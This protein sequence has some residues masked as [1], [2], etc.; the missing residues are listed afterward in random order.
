MSK[1]IEVRLSVRFR[2]VI[3]KPDGWREGPSVA[4]QV[5]DDVTVGLYAPALGVQLRGRV[6]GINSK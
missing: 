3:G 4:E 5:E 2:L 1:H 6:S